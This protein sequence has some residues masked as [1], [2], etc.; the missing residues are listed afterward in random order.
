MKTGDKFDLKLKGFDRQ[1]NPI[2]TTKIGDQEATCK[3]VKPEQGKPI[4]ENGV[5]LAAVSCPEHPG[6]LHGQVLSTPDDRCSASDVVST[7]KGPAKVTTEGYRN[8]WDRVF[9]K[10]LN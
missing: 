2:A 10:D 9:S 5:L 3:V 1:G 7:R 4:P 6:T 8:G